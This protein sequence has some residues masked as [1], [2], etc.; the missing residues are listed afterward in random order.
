MKP[1]LE[2]KG[3]VK[4]FHQKRNSEPIVVFDRFDFFVEVEASGEILVFLGASGCGKTTLLNLISGLTLPDEGE[5]RTLGDL[6]VGH[7]PHSVMVA[8]AYTCFPWLSALGNVEFGLVLRG[9]PKKE[10]TLLAVDYLKKVGLGDR[11]D[12]YPSELSGGMQQR[13]AIARTLVL[14]PPMVL[15][16]EPFGALDSQT[17]SQMQ[18]LLLRLWETEKNLIL[19]VTHDIQEA[20]LLADRI[21]LLPPRPIRRLLAEIRVPLARPRHPDLISQPAFLEVAEQLRKMLETPKS[22]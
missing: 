16:D 6:V 1:A 22:Q 8:Q 13:V 3:V 2:L 20:L 15:M 7:N 12:A 19:F 11:L 10:R 9:V 21:F 17:R 5:I 4:R 18:H 14:R